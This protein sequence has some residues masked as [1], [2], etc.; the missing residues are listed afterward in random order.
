[1]L[2]GCQLRAARGLLGINATTL[3][4]ESKVSLRTIRRAELEHGELSLLQENV[5]AL[6]D[7]LEAR[8]VIFDFSG[9]CGVALRQKPKPRFG[10]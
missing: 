5:S 4:H 10:D 3:A 8:G 2:R 7:A 9:T 1:M 6:V